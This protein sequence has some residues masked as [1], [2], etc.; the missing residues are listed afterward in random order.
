MPT[1]LRDLPAQ[2]DPPRKRWTRAEYERL[3]D[4]TLNQERLEL[5]NGELISKM[6]KKRPHVVALVLL[7]SWLTKAFGDRFVNP[8]APIDVA[9]E[10]NRS[11]EPEPDIIVLKRDM[12]EFLRSNPGP[13]DLR[14][15]AEISDTTLGYD[16]TAKA[17]LYARAR[18]L[19]YWVVDVQGSR[20][21]V[22]REPDGRRY[23]AVTAYSENECVAP[24]SAPESQL[25]VRDVIPG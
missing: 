18:I 7:Q 12:A 2:T 13:A 9:P 21:I 15:V 17:E 8:E 22:H 6:G 19:E 10:D 1:A 4:A 11:S 14:L 16:L 24:L 20:I 25:R 5:V 23:G 3:C